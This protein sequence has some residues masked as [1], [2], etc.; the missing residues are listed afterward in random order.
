MRWRM[1]QAGLDYVLL[2]FPLVDR[3]QSPELFR[4]VGWR[5]WLLYKVAFG[6][7]YAAEL[8]IHIAG[9]EQNFRAGTN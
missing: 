4:Q 9:H 7:S 8:A 2:C 3:Q 1:R 5:K 6:L